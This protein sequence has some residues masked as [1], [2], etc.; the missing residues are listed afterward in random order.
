MDSFGDR[1]NK[2]IEL[3]RGILFQQGEMAQLTFQSF[4]KYVQNINESEEQTITITY[5]IGFKPDNTTLDTTCI[6]S[7]QE[8]INRYDYLGL[9]QLPINGIYQLVTTIEALLGD[10]LRITLIEFPQKIS[11]KRKVDVDIILEASSIDEI[12][13]SVVNAVINELSYKSPRDFAEEFN[14]FIGVNLLEKPIFHRYIE[15]KATRD[16]YIHNQGI[17][18]E[19]YLAKADTLARVKQ[20]QHLPV[21]IHYFLQSYECC[22]QMT[23]ILEESLH[24]IW[25]STEYARRRNPVQSQE[26]NEIPQSPMLDEPIKPIVKSV[27]NN[28]KP[29][30]YKNKRNRKRKK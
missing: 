28:N 26:Q 6:Y 22:L 23:E 5:P 1:L 18:N 11:N 9:N 24:R 15:L 13:F 10:I 2:R 21:T 29:H 17:A 19:I 8:L 3:A 12:K 30:S 7:K 25:P 16:I 27:Q 4:Q 20:N 14:K